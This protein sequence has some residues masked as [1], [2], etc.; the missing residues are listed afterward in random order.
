MNGEKG[1]EYVTCLCEGPN[2]ALLLHRMQP[3][4]SQFGLR[5]RTKPVIG[6]DSLVRNG[7]RLVSQ[8][9]VHGPVLLFFDEADLKRGYLEELEKA[10]RGYD[11]SMSVPVARKIE[12]WLMADIVAFSKATGSRYK[13]PLPTDIMADP[14][15]E[16]LHYFRVAVRQEKRGFLAGEKDFFRAVV[17][18]WQLERARKNNLSLEAFCTLF[19]GK[20]HKEAMQ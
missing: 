1:R 8:Y 6:I 7:A 3:F 9:H 19:E 15:R 18:R 14:K 10:V 16:F 20:F 12:A 13:G 4:F 17:W 5:M 2:D 11:L